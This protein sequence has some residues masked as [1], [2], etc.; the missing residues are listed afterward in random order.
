MRLLGA[1]GRLCLCRRRDFRGL[2]L[3]HWQL[4]I[5]VLSLLATRPI[6]TLSFQL[7][8]HH[9]RPLNF[10]TSGMA[11]ATRKTR[12]A[13]S[14]IMAAKSD[15]SENVALKS[16]RKRARK[17]ADD[18]EDSTAPS[19]K[20]SSPKKK[21]ATKVKGATKATTK[22]A[23]ATKTKG[24]PTKKRA[25]KTAVSDNESI[26]STDSKGEAKK[27]KSPAKKKASDHQRI[28]ERDEIPKLWD[29][30]KASANGSYSKWC[31]AVDLVPYSPFSHLLTLLLSW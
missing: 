24:E 25:R 22:K 14:E 12:S 16:P 26:A 31:E 30:E 1:A 19:A 4:W 27:K 2:F 9:R 11:P 18:A 21:Q 20:T 23:T 7:A 17:S 8:L 3:N 10:A 28:T 5:P 15:D 13:S 6:A 29:A